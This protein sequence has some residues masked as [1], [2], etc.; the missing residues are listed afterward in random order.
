MDLSDASQILTGLLP[1]GEDLKKKKSHTAWLI[2][3]GTVDSFRLGGDPYLT[4]FPD[5]ALR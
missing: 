4:L 3:S 1:A 5:L 2:F